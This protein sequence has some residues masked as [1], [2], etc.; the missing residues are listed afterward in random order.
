[1]L[2]IERDDWGRACSGTIYIFV[3]SYSTQRHIFFLQSIYRIECREC[4]VCVQLMF[5]GTQTDY[6][7]SHDN[8]NGN[9]DVMVWHNQC[10]QYVDISH[11][12]FYPYHSPPLAVNR[13]KKA[14]KRLSP[15]V[16]CYCM[17]PCK[18]VIKDSAPMLTLRSVHNNVKFYFSHDWFWNLCMPFSHQ[19]GVQTKRSF[20]AESWHDKRVFPN[21][22]HTPFVLDWTNV[23]DTKR[24]YCT[25]SS[26]LA[27]NG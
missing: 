19:C 13:I 5:D 12:S 7:G 24:Q 27:Y 21:D 18:C 9:V 1:M 11:G 20:H 15:C 14:S 25:Q 10:Q 16:D 3:Y 17:F 22:G 23:M 8:N 4:S 6:I 2:R 26:I